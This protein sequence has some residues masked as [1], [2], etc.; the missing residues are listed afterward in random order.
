[1]NL[2]SLVVREE[3]E[4]SGARRKSFCSSGVRCRRNN[5]VAL[6]PVDG[7]VAG[8]GG[9][10]AVVRDGDKPDDFV[11]QQPTRSFNAPLT[12]GTPAVAAGIRLSLHSRL[13]PLNSYFESGGVSLHCV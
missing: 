5:P 6:P 12:R 4:D 1:M 8:H 7:Q 3:R 13:L 2:T 9:G 10:W 11:T